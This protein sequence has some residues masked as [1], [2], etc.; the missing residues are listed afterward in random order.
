[1]PSKD[2]RHLSLKVKTYFS[3]LQGLFVTVTEQKNNLL[4]KEKTLDKAVSGIMQIQTKELIF[5]EPQDEFRTLFI[6]ECP[7]LVQFKGIQE[8]ASQF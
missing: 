2:C 1:M 8:F 6:T 7:N 4:R 3:F 5:R